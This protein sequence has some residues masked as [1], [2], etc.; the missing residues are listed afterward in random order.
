MPRPRNGH[1]L[2]YAISP[3][4]LTS[5]FKGAT[6]IWAHTARKKAGLLTA[7]RR[8]KLKPAAAFLRS[9]AQA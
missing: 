2:T 7:R 6:S 4:A 5:D 8:R 1:R 9:Q 3:A